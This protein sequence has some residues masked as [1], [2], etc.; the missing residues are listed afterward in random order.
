MQTASWTLAAAGLSALLALAPQ[1]QKGGKDKKPD[2]KAKAAPAAV[3]PPLEAWRGKLE[4]AKVVAK[5]R[6]VPVLVHIL[7]EGEEA[8]NRYRDTI[9]K[10]PELQKRSA[11]AVVIIANQGSHARTKIDVVVEGEKVQ[12][13]VCLFYPMFESCAHHQAA[14]DELYQEFH[15]DNGDLMC[16]QTIVIAPDGTISGRINTSNVPQPSEIGA[17]VVEAVTK[18]GPGLT[19]AQ[20]AVVKRTLEAGRRLTVE[21]KWVLAWQSWAGVLLIT[22]KS[23]YADE[24]RLDQVKAQA[25]M[26]RDLDKISAELVPGTATTA[27]GALVK[28][29]AEL[30]G[31]PLEKEAQARLKKADGDKAIQPEIKAWKLSAEA[32]ALLG[33]ATKL[34]DAGDAKKAEKIVRKLLA[35]RFASTPAQ[36]TAR[37]LWP[38]IATEIGATPPK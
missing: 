37:K 24:A 19:E 16:P 10:D 4:D 38:D 13:E 15:E 18:A 21:G 6:N 23:P 30:V 31:T 28:Y 1:P 11:S 34:T 33:E 3:V 35:P 36:E 26:Q 7:L 8:S 25:G 2:P 29:A 17:L 9:F 20:L 27:Y 5:A 14:W 32:D 12:R 22:P